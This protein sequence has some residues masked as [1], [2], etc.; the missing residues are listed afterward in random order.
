[1]KNPIKVLQEE[2]KLLL[3]AIK[4]G[5]E[6]Q[7]I[8][9]DAIYLKKIHDYILFI[10][11]YTEIYHFPKE[12]LIFYPMLRNRSENMKPEFLH[13]ICDNH[14]DFK[15]F[16]AEIEN[17]Y[18][19]LDYRQLR[20][21]M[22]KYLKEMAEHMTSENKNILG[23]AAKLFSENE[24]EKLYDS[25]IELDEK[26]GDKEQLEKDFYKISSQLS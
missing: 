19:N 10:R 9:D 23:V 18:S 17:H 5:I 24:L 16:I 3:N 26:H 2:H 11:N 7:N 13:E 4:T 21:T 6:I 22:S 1:M 12:E 8:E 25:F 14:E 20:L 15:S